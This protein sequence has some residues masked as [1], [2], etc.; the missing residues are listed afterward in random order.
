M[1]IGIASVNGDLTSPISGTRYSPVTAPRWQTAS[2]L[3]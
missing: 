1:G 3:S 2:Q